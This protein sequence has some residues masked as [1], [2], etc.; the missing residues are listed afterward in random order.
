MFRVKNPQDFGAA[1]VFVLI[2]AAGLYFANDL[3]YGTAA[4]MGPGY[5][6]TLL[7]ALIAIIG[8][9]VGF[10]ALAIAGPSIEPIPLRPVGIIIGCIVGFGYLIEQV[11]VAIAATALIVVASYARRGANLKESMLLAVG[12]SIFVVAVFVYALGQPL[13][14]FWSR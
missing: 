9:V 1:I 11:G 13:Q 4:R 7:S 3:A 5:F 14:V 12:M 6:P 2:G 10:K 8:V